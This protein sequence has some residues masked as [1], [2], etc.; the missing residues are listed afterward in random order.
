[1]IATA[2]ERFMS[3]DTLKRNPA[4]KSV[5]LDIHSDQDFPSLSTLDFNQFST[6]KKTGAVVYYTLSK[7]TFF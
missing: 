6:P 3:Y 7:T 5:D 4:K 1:M 2:K